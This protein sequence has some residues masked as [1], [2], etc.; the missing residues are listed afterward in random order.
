MPRSRGSEGESRSGGSAFRV[1]ELVGNNL[2]KADQGWMSR[3]DWEM[4]WPE[5]SEGPMGEVTGAKMLEEEEV[6]S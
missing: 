2:D 3:W 4:G 1:R 5:P 6:R